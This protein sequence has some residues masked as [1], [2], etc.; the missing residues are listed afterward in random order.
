[1]SPYADQ[2]TPVS[3]PKYRSVRRKVV[4]AGVLV[5]FGKS[6]F[7]SPLH[8]AETSANRRI[9]VETIAGIVQQRRINGLGGLVEHPLLTECANAYASALSITSCMG[10][11]CGSTL[12]ERL[13]KSGYLW[14][15][16]AENLAWGYAADLVVTGWMGSPGH[17]ANILTPELHEIGLAVVASQS[18]SPSPVWVS[19]FGTRL[20]ERSGPDREAEWS[21]RPEATKVLGLEPKDEHSGKDPDPTRQPAWFW[22]FLSGKTR[23]FLSPSSP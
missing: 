9:V 11:E 10:H 5:A 23:S 21:A 12:T 8:G 6:G 7:A 3:P 15:R 1:M 22:K 14:S 18:S 4:G 19:V 16:C 2:S 20:N 13:R 17:R